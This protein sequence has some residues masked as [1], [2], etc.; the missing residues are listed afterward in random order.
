MPHT[1]IMK[2]GWEENNFFYFLAL[3]SISGL[4]GIF[5]Q[6]IMRTLAHDIAFD[7]FDTILEAGKRTVHRDQGQAEERVR[8]DDA[9]GV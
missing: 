1:G 9:R 2:R 4:Y 8:Q 3:D 5:I 7:T 6:H